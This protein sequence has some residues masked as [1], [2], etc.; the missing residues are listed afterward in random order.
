MIRGNI[1]IFCLL[2]TC[3]FAH[4]QEGYVPDLA[5]KKTVIRTIYLAPKEDNVKQDTSLLEMLVNT[6][7]AGNLAAYEPYGANFSKTI[8]LERLDEIING[9]VDTL[10]MAHWITNTAIKT[11]P[12]AGFSYDS[13]HKYRVLEEWT[14]NP[15][16]GRTEIQITGVAPV[17]DIIG[18]DNVYRGSQAMFFVHYSE[19]LPVLERYAQ[20]HRGRSLASLIWNDYFL[21]DIKTQALK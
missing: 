11:L 12:H 4:A 6:I 5:W 17:K 1:A 3:V 19:A 10:P 16:T 18:D 20:S 2:C 14:L 9:K 13:I 21:S 7:K 8:N 15:Q